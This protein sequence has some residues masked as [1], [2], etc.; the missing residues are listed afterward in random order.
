[1]ACELPVVV[2]PVGMNAEVLEKGSVGF[3]AASERD[4]VDHL[5]VLLRNPELGFQMGRVGREVVLKNY[6]VDAL[7]PQLAKILWRVT[8]RIL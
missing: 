5:E 7:A 2:S 4:W 1:M 3:G 8:G 6:S